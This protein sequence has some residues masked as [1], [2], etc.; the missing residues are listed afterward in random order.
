[1][2]FSLGQYRQYAG[3]EGAALVAARERE[4]CEAE[5][6]DHEGRPYDTMFADHFQLAICPLRLLHPAA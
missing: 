6:G 2:M 5:E 3:F 4:A 1:M